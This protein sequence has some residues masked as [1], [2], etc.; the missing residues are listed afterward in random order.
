MIACLVPRIASGD[1]AARARAIS[2]D[3][4]DQGLG[5]VGAVLSTH[6]VDQAH[7]L[8]LGAADVAAGV[9]HLARPALA[10]DAG[11]AL[12]DADVG[13]EAHVD[14]L[15][16]ELRARGGVAQVAGDGEVEAG[17][18][19]DA[20]DRGEDGDTAALDGGEDVLEVEDQPAQRLARPAGV[21]AVGGHALDLAEHREVDAR[22][23]VLPGAG[24]DDDPHARVGVERG[25]GVAQ[26][27]PQRAVERV[28]GLGALEAHRRDAAVVRDRQR[29]RGGR[30]VQV[31][32]AHVR[33]P[34][35]GVQVGAFLTSNASVAPRLARG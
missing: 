32:R 3:V 4:R 30:R 5:L 28:R 29:G 2:C 34:L 26:L 8:G 14:L 17:A 23:E 18:D 19:A 35:A 15:E 1:F 12:Q 22:A 11:Q 10:D 20:L 13:G 9:G 16:R 6:A 21:G 27:A 7:R 33:V 25:E 31:E 24:E